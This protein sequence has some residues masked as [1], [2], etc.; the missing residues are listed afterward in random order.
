MLRGLAAELVYSVGWASPLENLACRGLRVMRAHNT[1]KIL[2]VM[3]LYECYS[4]RS[5]CISSDKVSDI[6]VTTDCGV[7]AGNIDA[8]V[9]CSVRS[10]VCLPIWSSYTDGVGSS[11]DLSS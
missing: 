1:Q 9:W 11:W 2:V 6:E 3:D 4:I 7:E 10:L 5:A 8:V